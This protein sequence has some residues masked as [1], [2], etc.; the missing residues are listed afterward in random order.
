MP[1]SFLGCRSA[2]FL[3]LILLINKHFSVTGCKHSSMAASDLGKY[4]TTLMMIF[5]SVENNDVAWESC[6]SKIFQ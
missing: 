5:D 6:S 3:L 2:T 1:A 4:L